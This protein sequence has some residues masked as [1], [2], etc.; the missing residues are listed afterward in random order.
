LGQRKTRVQPTK[1]AYFNRLNMKNLAFS[2]I[3][4]KIFGG[5]LINAQAGAS[6]DCDF[7]P[8]SS[9]TQG[10]ELLGRPLPLFNTH[11]P[12]PQVNS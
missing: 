4:Q 8:H 5:G 11:K 6:C 12:N 7:D 2:D 10:S 9:L 3:L 1:A